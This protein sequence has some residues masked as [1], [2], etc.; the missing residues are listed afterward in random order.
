MP[1]GQSIAPVLTDAGSVQELNPNGGAVTNQE[2]SL[3]VTGDITRA[4]ITSFNEYKNVPNQEYS[5]QHP[6]AQ[7]DGDDEGRGETG[8]GQGVGTIIDEQRKDVLLYSSGNKYQPGAGNNYYN[9]SFGEQ[10]W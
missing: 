5:A 1:N 10:Y 9:F 8:P 7:S 4:Q 6:N 2:P 3:K